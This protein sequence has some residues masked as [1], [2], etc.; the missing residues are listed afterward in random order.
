MTDRPQGKAITDILKKKYLFKLKGTGPL[1]LTDTSDFDFLVQDWS[2][3]PYSDIQEKYPKN[4][5][6]ARKACP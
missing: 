2:N 3:T 1:R 4:L 6:L 5:P